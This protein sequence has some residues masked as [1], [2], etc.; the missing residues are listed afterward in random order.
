MEILLVSWTGG[1]KYLEV[2]IDIS[3]GTNYISMGSTQLLSVPYA[4][5]SANSLPGPSGATGPTG[6]TGTAGSGGGA[7]GS[8]GPTGVNGVSGPTGVQGVTGPTGNTGA[9]G[10]TGI[11]FTGTT[12]ATGVQGIQGNTGPTGITTI[13]ATGPTGA[14]GIMGPTG[15]QSFGLPRVVPMPDAATFTLTPD[16]ADENTQLNTQPTGLL[17]VNAPSGTPRD[18][19]KIIFRIKSTNVQTFVW[20]L[21]FRGSTSLPLPTATSG[22]ENTDYAIF[23]YNAADSKWDLIVSVFGFQSSSIVNGIIAYWKMDGNSIDMVNGHNGADA[24]I[25]YSNANGIINNGAGFNGLSSRIVVPQDPA[26]SPSNLSVSFWVKP[27]SLPTSNNVMTIMT[28]R[29]DV[30]GSGGWGIEL[31]NNGGTQSIACLGNNTGAP[32]SNVTYTLPLGVFTHVVVTKMSGGNAK[33][34]VN[35]GFLGADNAMWAMSNLQQCPL[36]LVTD[37]LIL[38][39]S[40]APLMK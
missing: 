24:N 20:N 18:G 26:L 9:I 39:G 14:T 32:T 12:G 27:L 1:E 8:T 33:V 30:S 4:L 7:T 15:P 36:L 22:A 28:K 3:G 10:A 23:I 17:T 21:V 38:N 2:L 25:S 5:F 35:G 11:G 37:L 31:Y 34:Y 19:Q 29:D 13:G 6:P 16:S 40:M